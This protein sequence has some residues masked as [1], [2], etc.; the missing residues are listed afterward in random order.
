MR[1]MMQPTFSKGIN[2]EPAKRKENKYTKER[3]KKDEKSQEKA[4]THTAVHLQQ[5]NDNTS[6]DMECTENII[7]SKQ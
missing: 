7:C 4:D 3:A 6:V 2:N 1:M 5:K